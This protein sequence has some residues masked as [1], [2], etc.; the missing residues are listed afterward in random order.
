[1]VFE[2]RLS[3][4]SSKN[5]IQYIENNLL[6]VQTTSVPEDGKANKTLIKILSKELKIAKSNIEIIKG[7]KN[8]NKTIL[9]KNK[10]IEDVLNKF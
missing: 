2:V 4:N 8:R 1:M 6:K 9:I 5:Q 7:S 10:N 3:P